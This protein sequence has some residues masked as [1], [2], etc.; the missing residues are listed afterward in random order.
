VE[1]EASRA[2]CNEAAQK[3]RALGDT[4]PSSAEIRDMARLLWKR[5]NPQEV[6]P[7]KI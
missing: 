2:L 5:Q 4:N 1:Y 7:W 3:L 6:P